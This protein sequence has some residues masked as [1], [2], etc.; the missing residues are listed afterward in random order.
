MKIK[1]LNSGLLVLMITILCSAL[2][3]NKDKNNPP[4][5]LPPITQ[6]GKNTFGCKID[7]EIWVPYYKCGGTG[8]TCG[9]L[10]VD[11][12]PAIIQQ[13]ILIEINMSFTKKNQDNSSTGFQ[14]NTKQNFK[15]FTTGNKIDSL[16]IEFST[17]GFKFYRN[18]NNNGFFQITKLDTLNNIISGLF[19]TT[20]YVSA[21]DSVKITEGR[22]DLR[23]AACKCSN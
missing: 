22:F 20:L 13:K 9:E 7:G 23:F 18:S 19:E 15:L 5:T 17:S 1:N 10:F 4:T 14:I 12:Y 11:V 2:Q 8:N 6:E 21:T 3:C 16:N